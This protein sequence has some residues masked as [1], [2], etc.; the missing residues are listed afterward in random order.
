MSGP[1]CAGYAILGPYAR[2]QGWAPGEI[3]DW[4][5]GATGW[6][7]WVS[8]AIMLGDSL[9]SLSLLVITSTKCTKCAPEESPAQIAEI[10]SSTAVACD[11]IMRGHFGRLRPC[12]S[13]D[14]NLLQLFHSAIRMLRMS[15]TDLYDIFL[16][17]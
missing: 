4:K 15:P 9:T 12:V 1:W 8:L 14:E 10:L 7:L 17:H 2:A 11:S 16:H 13:W 5:N 3:M 6:I